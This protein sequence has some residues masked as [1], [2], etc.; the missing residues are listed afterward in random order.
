MFSVLDSGLSSLGSSPGSGYYTV[1]FDK[2]FYLKLRGGGGSPAID[3]HPIQGGV[4]VLLL[5]LCSEIR[6]RPGSIGLWPDGDVT[7]PLALK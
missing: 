7:L 3:Y 5:T 2:T 1:F 4:E 6:K